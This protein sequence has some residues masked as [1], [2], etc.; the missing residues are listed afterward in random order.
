MDSTTLKSWLSDA[1]H[2]R[3]QR[4]TRA[5]RLLDQPELTGP[6]LHIGFGS[7]RELAVRAIWVVEYAV[8]QN[9]PLLLPYLPLLLANSGQVADQQIVRPLAKML[10]VMLGWS[11]K[12]PDRGGL[13][14]DQKNAMAELCFDWLIGDHKVAAKAHSMSSL[15]FLG[16]DLA[17]IHRELEL[18]LRQNYGSG[19]AAYKAR[20][21]MVLAKIGRK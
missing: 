3:L 7:E 13:T 6:L 11:Y 12:Q 16:Q 5:K 14:H 4:A 21:R 17:W 8:K 15:Y 1:D 9:P 18:L 19:S 10:E 2:T 20:A